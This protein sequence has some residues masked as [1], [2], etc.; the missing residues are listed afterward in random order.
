M[1][2]F[3]ECYRSSSDDDYY[4][5]EPVLSAKSRRNIGMT[6]AQFGEGFRKARSLVCAS[7]D[8]LLSRELA[9][10]TRLS[11][12]VAEN[13]FGREEPPDQEGR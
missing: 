13:E 6:L 10:M 3:E 11:F 9:I 1:A 12:A 2:E 5:L 8:E 4:N 7:E